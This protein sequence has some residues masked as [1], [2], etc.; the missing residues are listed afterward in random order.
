MNKNKIQHDINKF[1]KR[2]IRDLARSIKNFLIGMVVVIVL[3]SILYFII[4]LW[5]FLIRLWYIVTAPFRETQVTLPKN[6]IRIKI[7]D[8]FHQ[9]DDF[10]VWDSLSLIC[11]SFALFLLCSSIK[12]SWFGWLVIWYHWD[13]FITWFA[14]FDLSISMVVF[15]S[16]LFCSLVLFLIWI[17]F[18][19]KYNLKGKLN[20]FI[21]L[22]YYDFLFDKFGYITGLCKTD[23]IEVLSWIPR[24]LFTLILF[25]FWI[26]VI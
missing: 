10:I 22:Y 16:F 20:T 19:S 1:V 4:F 13:L 3:L 23:F 9:L 18:Y 11:I 17:V 5:Y 7:S 26:F 14:S 6:E 25:T 8:W 15:F 21:K 24:I 2:I 12:T